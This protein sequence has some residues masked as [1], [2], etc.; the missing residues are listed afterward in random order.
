LPTPVVESKKEVSSKKVNTPIISKIAKK[1][2]TPKLPVG[3]E[4]K[5]D[6]TPTKKNDTLGNMNKQALPMSQ[7]SDV[8]YSKPVPKSTS[9]NGLRNIFEKD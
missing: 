3:T 2:E 4:T 6:L 1:Q 9:K 5:K 8:V 7:K